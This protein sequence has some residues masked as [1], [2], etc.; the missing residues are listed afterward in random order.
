MMNEDTTPLQPIQK[1][2]TTLPPITRNPNPVKLV[3][4]I[5]TQDM[6]LTNLNSRHST[7]LSTNGDRLISTRMT[8]HTPAIPT[9]STQMEPKNQTSINEL[10]KTKEA[11]MQQPHEVDPD[12]IGMPAHVIKASPQLNQGKEK[13]MDSNTR[14][15]PF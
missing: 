15:R 3:G 10:V 4:N 8:Q 11:K 14:L 2:H 12:H 13:E 9:Q 6:P 5:P 1:D 7:P